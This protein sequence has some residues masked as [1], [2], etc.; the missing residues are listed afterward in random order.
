M[1]M[2]TKRRS[3]IKALGLAAVLSATTLAAHAGPI[4]DIKARG[5]IRIGVLSELPPW[6]Y[7]DSNGKNIGYDV[8]VGQLLA[9][10]LGVK[11]EFVSMNVAARIP[12]LMTGKVDLLIATMGMY[13]DRAKVVQ[14]SKPY[15]AMS[16]IVL[17]KK[18]DK[19]TTFDDLA[20]KRIGVPRAAAQDIAIT[21]AAP[22]STVIQRFDDD[23]AV[24]QA[25]VAGQVDAIGANTTYLININKVMPNHAFEEKIVLNRQYMGVAMKPGQKELNLWINQFIDG[26][27][28]SGELN[29]INQKWIAQDLPEL[30]KSMQDVPFYVD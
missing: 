9:K 11:A 21:Q 27:Q 13:P 17:G 4:E 23:S 8:D 20:G 28:A 2:T 19:I 26:I 22:K 14:F 24:V 30:V 7:L 15:A 29:A 3:I 5:A 10:K 25:L 6:G 12:S 16:I 18:S 1:T